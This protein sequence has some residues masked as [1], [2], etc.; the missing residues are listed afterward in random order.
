MDSAERARR[1]RERITVIILIGTLSLLTVF[2]VHILRLSAKLPFVNSI[3]FFGLMNL[4]IVLIMILLFLVFR[5]VVKLILDEKRGRAGSRLRTRL[6]FS[7]ILFAIIPTVLLFAISATYIKTSFDKWFSAKVESTLQ[8]SI[9]VVKIYYENTEKNA[10]HFARRIAATLE[11]HSKRTLGRTL[12]DLRMEYGVDALEYYVNPFL[13]R[14]LSTHPDKQDTIPSGS[15]ETLKEVFAGNQS[16]RIQ[17]IGTGEL[18][19][20]GVFLGTGKGAI[21]VDYFIPTSLASQLSEINMTFEDFKRNN[22]LDYPIKSTYF[23]ILTM[24]TLL[25]LFSAIWTGFYI[26]KRLTVPIEELLRGTEAVA[27]GNLDFRLTPGGQDELA[28]LVE[29]FNL[30]V[31]D[32]NQN[33]IDIE[34]SHAYLKKMNEELATRRRYIEV[35]LESVQS[36]VVSLDEFGKIS[37]VNGAA[38]KL[39]SLAP[40]DLV[41]KPY[42]SIVPDSYRKDFREILAVLSSS[43][44]S[45]IRKEIRF[46]NRDGRWVS[47]LITLSPFRDENRRQRGVVAVID[48]VT[49]IQK[50][51]RMSAWREVARR[52]AHEIKNPLTPIQLSVER[53]R[54]RYLDKI[55]DDGTFDQSTQIILKEVDSLKALVGEFTTFARLPEVIQAP[56]DLN[57]LII[58]ASNLFRAA[59][60]KIQFQLDLAEGLPLLRLDRAQLKRAFINLFDNAVTAMNGSGT[61]SVRSFFASA[62]DSYCLSIADSGCG[63]D[64]AAQS[65]LF[66]PYFS[67][68]EGGTGLGLAIVQRI[69]SDH[70]GY[71]RVGKNTPSGTKF[72]IELPDSLMS[73]RAGP[74]ID[75]KPNPIS[76]EREVT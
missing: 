3:F 59:H 28:K 52:I 30:M 39:L 4:N 17:N 71:I 36:G 63:I 7:F 42:W 1:R 51:E 23:A 34:T 61:I 29:S 6:V 76:M 44:A 68:K 31:G 55:R 38:S 67:T 45:P 21:F 20:C 18:V 66:E 65:Q 40:A 5:N 26:A 8:R 64:E 37:T 35:L 70:G 16:C 27:K 72:T 47:L 19:R 43:S 57:A 9:E 10:Q 24:V 12:D 75:P 48:D 58:D 2:E 22:P 13:P 14:V 53:L 32:L 25:I 46:Q 15:L 60:E 54:R 56:E 11:T 50:I 74:Q 69:I 41:N 62:I 33:K 73:P 49:E